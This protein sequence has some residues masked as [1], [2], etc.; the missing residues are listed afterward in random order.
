MLVASEC[1][2]LL[3]VQSSQF[4]FAERCKVTPNPNIIVLDHF[5]SA[6][7][8]GAGV[9]INPHVHDKTYKNPSSE[10]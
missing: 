1:E 10:T 7:R 4:A 5:A 6:E 8:V 3:P 9:F 2:G